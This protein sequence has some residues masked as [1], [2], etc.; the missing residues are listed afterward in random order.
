M[1]LTLHTLFTPGHE[2]FFNKAKTKGGKGD[3]ISS[4]VF[5]GLSFSMQALFTDRKF[6]KPWW[7]DICLF[8]N[9]CANFQFGRIRVRIP[10]KI[11]IYQLSFNEYRPKLS[12][13]YFFSHS[14]H[15]IHY[16]TKKDFRL[17]PMFLWIRFDFL[18]GGLI[19]IRIRIFEGSYRQSQ[20]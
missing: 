13:S 8:V 15:K 14:H 6:C 18:G 11:C 3:S 20:P 1:N 2:I 5:M 16:N 19:W 17:G 4:Q 9:M 7:L 10:S 12:C